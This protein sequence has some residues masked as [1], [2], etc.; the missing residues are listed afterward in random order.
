MKVIRIEISD[1]GKGIPE[2]MK[3]RIFD[4]FYTTK[5]NGTGLG[6]SLVKRIVNEHKGII[7][8]I[9]KPG[10]GTK[11]VILIPVNDLEAKFIKLQD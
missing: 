1:N 8:F 7:D 9:S 4:P 10:E 2:S 5:L 3:K 6:L 11:F